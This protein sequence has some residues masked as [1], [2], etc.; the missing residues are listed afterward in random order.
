M[1]RDPIL[2]SG[3]DAIYTLR[4]TAAGPAGSLPL[5]AD[6]LR[7]MASGDLFKR[8]IVAIAGTSPL[9]RKLTREVLDARHPTTG[10]SLTLAYV[11]GRSRHSS[12][13]TQVR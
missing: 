2:D 8:K 4:T 6:R 3:N 13:S 1:S 12:I 10:D 11:G 5:D 9:R 7:R